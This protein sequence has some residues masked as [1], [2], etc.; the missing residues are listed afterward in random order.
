MSEKKSNIFKFVVIIVSIIVVA[1]LGALF[2]N[3]GLDW[4]DGLVKPSRFVAGVAISIV[5]GIIYSTFAVVLCVWASKKDLPL[6]TIIL[7]ILNGA[8]NV[9]W[10]LL[11]FTLNNTILGLIA[12][13]VNL[14]LAYILLINIY[15]RQKIYAYIF[16][17]Y[18]LWVSIATNLNLAL[19][20]LN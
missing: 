11:F 18:P 8:L 20:I 9:V 6:S 13:I 2:V 16:S 12:I 3:L 14:I 17:I 7:L 5:W 15:S 19:W 4:F 1:S 10:C